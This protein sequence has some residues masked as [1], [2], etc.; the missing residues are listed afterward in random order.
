MQW[1][2]PFELIGIIR[3]KNFVV[4]CYDVHAFTYTQKKNFFIHDQIE[5]IRIRIVL[6]ISND[7]HIN[8]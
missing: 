7:Q 5:C 3:K 6:V 2:I 4:K 1:S 8:L